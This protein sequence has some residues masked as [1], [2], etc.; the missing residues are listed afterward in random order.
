MLVGTVQ[1]LLPWGQLFS[2]Q[3][4]VFKNTIWAK[5]TDKTDEKNILL[6]AYECVTSIAKSQLS[7]NT[8]YFSVAISV[9][10]G[11]VEQ[12]RDVSMM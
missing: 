2:A 1:S 11:H 5:Y 7:Q 4:L 9:F 6:A 10:D 8:W 3:I 12:S